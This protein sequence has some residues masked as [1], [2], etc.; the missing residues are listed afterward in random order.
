VGVGV[1]VRVGV[2]VIGGGAGS[3]MI[4]VIVGVGVG[5]VV[6]G[7]AGS[8][9][10]G[11]QLAVVALLVSARTTKI[12]LRTSLGSLFQGTIG[13]LPLENAERVRHSERCGVLDL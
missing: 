4:G 6:G 13:R 5:V 3:Q 1:A 8:H 9:T 12:V 11:P 7:G 10:I 2:A